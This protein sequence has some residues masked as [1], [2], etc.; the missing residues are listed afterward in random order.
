MRKRRPS[1]ARQAIATQSAERGAAHR[2]RNPSSSVGSGHPLP[3]SRLHANKERGGNTIASL[4]PKHAFYR[5]CGAPEASLH[6][7]CASL[8]CGS[9]QSPPAQSS[10]GC[11]GNQTDAVHEIRVI[12]SRSSA[13]SPRRDRYRTVDLSICSTSDARPLSA[14]CS[15]I[16]CRGSG[17]LTPCASH[18]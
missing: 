3:G 7:R 6:G 15:A 8:S 16:A 10:H 17:W 2:I 13:S 18:R 12:A 9:S 5:L 11:D 14:D 4:C 1:I